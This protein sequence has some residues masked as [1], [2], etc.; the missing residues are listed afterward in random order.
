VTSG[1]LASDTPSVA[2]WEVVERHEL[3]GWAAD[4]LAARH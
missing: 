4:V 2:G 3:E 1:Y